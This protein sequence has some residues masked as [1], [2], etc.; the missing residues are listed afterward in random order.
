M[1]KEKYAISETRGTDPHGMI[2]ATAGIQ[3]DTLT[4]FPYC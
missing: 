1:D 2:P 4:P 3:V